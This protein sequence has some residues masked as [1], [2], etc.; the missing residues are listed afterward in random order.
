MSAVV[1]RSEAALHLFSS[2]LGMA[3][4]ETLSADKISLTEALG[5]SDIDTTRVEAFAA[6]T[7]VGVGVSGYLT[8][9]HGADVDVVLPDEPMLDALTGPLVLLLPDA[10]PRDT[11]SL[12]PQDPLRHVASYPLQKAAAA[13]PHLRTPSADG[14]VTG[15]PPPIDRRKA[16]RK[17]SGYVAL[18]A[19]LTLFFIV[20]VMVWI[21]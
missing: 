20:G 14:L 7:L 4:T 17:A 13:Q 19:L 21:A 15:A 12:A 10:L 5:V 1:L 16:D 9:G 6:E 2:Q 11:R 18:V 8:D 3:E